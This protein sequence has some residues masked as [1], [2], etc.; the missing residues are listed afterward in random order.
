MTIYLTC[1]SP[2]ES[3]KE[4]TGLRVWG[5]PLQMLGE[6]QTGKHTLASNDAIDKSPKTQPS[7]AS[8]TCQAQ[9]NQVQR[10]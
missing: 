7:L 5:T 1:K 6:K 10:G 3:Q 9:N 2:S 8:D 4:A